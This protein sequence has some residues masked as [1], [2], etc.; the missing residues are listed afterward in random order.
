MVGL[1]PPIPSDLARALATYMA[2]L[3]PNDQVFL[4]PT[5]SVSIV[6]AMRR[7]LKGPGI[8]SKLPTGEIVDFHTLRSTAITWG[9]DEDRLSQ[10]RVQVLARLK[11]QALVYKYSRNWRLEDFSWLESD[12]KLVT[13]VQRK[14]AT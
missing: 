2:Y 10:K 4:L 12:P 5:T 9:L 6:D 13:K 8:P 11:T 3:Q 14:K 7:D 1:K